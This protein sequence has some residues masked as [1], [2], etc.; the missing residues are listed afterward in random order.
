MESKKTGSSTKKAYRKK[1][2][3][4]YIE[5]LQK[6]QKIKECNINSRYEIHG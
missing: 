2:K 6:K 3:I 5:N 4:Q 1:R